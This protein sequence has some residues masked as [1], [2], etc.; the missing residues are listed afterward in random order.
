MKNSANVINELLEDESFQSFALGKETGNRF[1]WD[2]WI[3]N[4]PDKI[5]DVEKAIEI[6]NSFSI[7]SI[8]VDE[9]SYLEDLKKIELMVDSDKQ[10]NQFKIERRG[11]L[12]IAA[13]V[14]ILLSVGLAYLFTERQENKEM[15]AIST[16]EKSNPKGRKSTV[17]LLDG[18]KV[19]LNSES[20]I[21]YEED[22]EKGTREVYLKGEAFFDVAKD[23]SRPFI[24]HSGDLS[25]TAL[26]TS[27][28][29][30]AYDEKGTLKIYLVTGEVEVKNIR[31][32]ESLVLEP[33]FGVI[34]KS[35]D[36][37]LI[38]TR[39]DFKEELAW[40]RGSIIFKNSDLSDITS[41]LERWYGVDFV[42]KGKPE[43]AWSV[44]GEFRNETL[45]NIL[46]SIQD[47]TPFE[48][49]LKDDVVT[50]RF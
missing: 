10:V 30:N 45:K 17:M 8:E 9:R 38:K 20:H 1:Y 7:K 34:F 27:F 47:T 49:V 19:N 39:L 44:N 24:V 40:K 12:W 26:G 3:K 4:H 2:N 29:V 25:T 6:I 43:N 13:S 42:I 28:N 46:N 37:K 31:N 36:N 14:T 22:I 5:A 11:F 16:L 21:K 50:I 23:S 18:T 15:Q 35:K 48:Y 41:Q 33:G 32:N